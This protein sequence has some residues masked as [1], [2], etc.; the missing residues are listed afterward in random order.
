MRNLNN[1]KTEVI[2]EFIELGL[3]ESDIKF[4]NAS[5]CVNLVCEIVI[6]DKAGTK[7]VGH[8]YK[9]YDSNFNQSFV[10]RYYQD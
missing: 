9:T 7:I 3:N 8:I 5:D 1:L 4:N 10:A 2:N 6:T